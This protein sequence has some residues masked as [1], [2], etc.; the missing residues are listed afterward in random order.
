MLK[1]LNKLSLKTN[2]KLSFGRTTE[3]ALLSGYAL[4]VTSAIEKIY[5]VLYSK[6]K[7]K[8]LLII[9]G[10][11]GKEILSNLTI[12]VKY[13]PNLVLKCLGLISSRK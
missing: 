12:K 8:P 11:Y 5:S 7:K 9:S 6:I 10:G 1:N 2:K 13:E 3:D 4:M